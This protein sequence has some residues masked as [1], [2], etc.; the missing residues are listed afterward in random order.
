MM[1][2]IAVLEMIDRAPLWWSIQPIRDLATAM[3]RVTI[4]G[5]AGDPALESLPFTAGASFGIK[6][7]QEKFR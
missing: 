1:S 3:A 5:A 2:A 7:P 4:E 6:R